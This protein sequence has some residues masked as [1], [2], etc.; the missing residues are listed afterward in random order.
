MKVRSKH[1]I[2]LFLFTIANLVSSIA[3]IAQESDKRICLVDICY[4]CTPSGCY[5]DGP[6]KIN[7]CTEDKCPDGSE[8]E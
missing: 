1:L 8:D 2:F 7:P 3:S 4:I 6:N 5:I